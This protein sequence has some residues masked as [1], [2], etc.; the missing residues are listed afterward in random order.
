MVRNPCQA[1]QDH[2]TLGAAGLSWKLICPSRLGTQSMQA[3]Q[4]CPLSAV[5]MH[6]T[7]ATRS[8]GTVLHHHH[9]WHRAGVSH[10]LGGDMSLLLSPLSA[11]TDP[12]DP[13]PSCC[14]FTSSA[15]CSVAA[16]FERPC[17]VLQRQDHIFNF[18]GSF[19]VHKVY[20]NE[21]TGEPLLA[22]L[23]GCDR[24]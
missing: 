22:S 11:C 17:P 15:V 21:L 19:P 5:L 24:N 23:E 8:L 18:A 12:P 20:T 2:T 4:I 6:R 14:H 3:W 13:P 1:S 9:L 16:Q 10:S 7:E